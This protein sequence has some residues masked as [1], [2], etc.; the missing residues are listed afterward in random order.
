MQPVEHFKDKYKGKT[1]AVLG[2]GVSLAT[3]LRQIE[4]VDILIGVNQHSLI[5][6][7]DFLV[8]RDRDVWPLINRIHDCRFVTQLNKFIDS[9]VVHAGIC[10]PIGY[11][12]GMAI[13]FADY[14]GFDRIDV[15]GMDQYDPKKH[16]GR[17]YWWEG[18]Q[19]NL[20]RKHTSCNS[21]LGRTKL[22]VDTLQHPERIWF[23]SGRLKELHQ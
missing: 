11:S 14:L 10:P 16:E 19:T 9:R 18:P 20:A 6:P 22:F 21:D 2:G 1:C 13:W 4:P 23:V 3:D 7:L 12:G 15:C 17:E 8:F 5:L